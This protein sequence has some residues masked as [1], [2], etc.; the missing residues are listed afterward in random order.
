VPFFLSRKISA[1]LAPLF[2]FLLLASPK[3]N[4]QLTVDLPFNLSAKNIIAIERD[5]NGFYW[6][7]SNNGIIS[8]WSGRKFVTP[9]RYSDGSKLPSDLNIARASNGKLYVV[10]TN[11][12]VVGSIDSLSGI[13]KVQGSVS[14][15]S[16]PLDNIEHL[17]LIEIEKNNAAEIFEAFKSSLTKE[18]KL[19][20]IAA[21]TYYIITGQSVYYYSNRHLAT[22][23]T[24]TDIRRSFFGIVNGNLIVIHDGNYK[25][26]KETE[27]ITQGH[28]IF[29]QGST[30]A[31]TKSNLNSLSTKT[32]QISVDNRIIN[33]E[34]LN[35]RCVFSLLLT[36]DAEDKTSFFYDDADKNVILITTAD[37]LQLNHSSAIQ[38]TSNVDYLSANKVLESCLPG[39]S[40]KVFDDVE[41][42]LGRPT[43]NEQLIKLDD[44][45]LYRQTDRLYILDKNLAVLKSQAI[46]LPKITAV[47]KNNGQLFICANGLFQL[48]N[49]KNTFQKISIPEIDINEPLKYIVPGNK[50]SLF[51]AT[52]NTIYQLNIVLGV[53]RL[54]SLT[55]INNVISLAYDKTGERLFITTEKNGVYCFDI[56]TSKLL[57]LPIQFSESISCS[58]YIVIDKDGDYWLATSRGLYILYRKQLDKYLNN[59]TINS[60]LYL[61]FEKSTNFTTENIPSHL[62]KGDTILFC[63]SKDVIPIATKEIKKSFNALP[64][65]FLNGIEINNTPA[66]NNSI[67]SLPAGFETLRLNFDFPIFR[68][69]YTILEYQVFGSTD[70]SWKPLQDD[71]AVFIR[72]LPTGKYKLLIRTV[73]N[74]PSLLYEQVFSVG[75]IWSSSSFLSMVWLT[76]IIILIF[77]VNSLYLSSLRNKTLIDVDTNR[78]QLFTV[79]A[80]DLRSPINSY[81][82]LGETFNFYVKKGD[83]EKVNLISQ[84]IEK[85]GNNLNLLLDNLLNWSLIAQEKFKPR[86]E[87]IIIEDLVNELIPIYQLTADINNITINFAVEGEHVVQTDK[88]LLSLIIRNL[89]DNATQNAVPKSTIDISIATTNQTVTFIL[90]NNI[91]ELDKEKIVEILNFLKNKAVWNPESSGIGIGLIKKATKEI[92]AQLR[93]E[94]EESKV[95]WKLHLP[96]NTR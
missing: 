93:V 21:S 81:Q 32:L 65:L 50:E 54:K 6:L 47:C 18:S 95:Y 33:I 59:P 19:L 74:N 91:Y 89:L 25:V 80:H 14:D 56:K 24:A 11:G 17:P 22:V 53:A 9:E 76:I 78:K 90:C 85:S 28:N 5:D 42:K 61:K 94:V 67:E 83:F 52:R 34:S 29:L 48:S 64:F 37:K 88:L 71:G 39:I 62:V 30:S 41:K 68:T 46:S 43:S 1:I 86:K 36:S 3:L 2:L 58:Q 44:S 16:F 79:I 70:T 45:F 82:H 13:S 87:S 57:K 49:I 27:L 26:F 23:S 66:L 7:L 60:S 51:V 15:V 10:S 40:S 72:G 77:L 4:A 31:A 63:S 75:S 38:R 84:H 92:Q 35:N 96:F 69:P 73:S 8:R 55:P 20:H 12:D